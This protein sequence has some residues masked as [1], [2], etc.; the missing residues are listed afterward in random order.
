MTETIFRNARIV[1]PDG[2][3]TGNLV[4]RDGLIVAMAEYNVQVEPR[5]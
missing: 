3:V 5:D 1:Q 2:I 4:V